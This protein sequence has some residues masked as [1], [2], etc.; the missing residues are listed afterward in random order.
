MQTP[1]LTENTPAD[2]ESITE[3]DS[4]PI[5]GFEGVIEPDSDP[6]VDSDNEGNWMVH[7]DAVGEHVMEETPMCSP[8]EDGIPLTQVTESQIAALDVPD[9]SYEFPTPWNFLHTPSGQHGAHNGT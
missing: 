7:M 3:P 2:F 6:I 5:I 9:E 1:P 8:L 4:D